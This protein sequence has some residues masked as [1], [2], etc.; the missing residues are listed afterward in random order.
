MGESPQI[1]RGAGCSIP[2]RK[3]THAGQAVQGWAAQ[4][5]APPSRYLFLPIAL[6]PRLN[7]PEP[8]K[9]RAPSW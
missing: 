1:L 3:K 5:P 8:S 6:R 9:Q 2:E 4:K 7:H